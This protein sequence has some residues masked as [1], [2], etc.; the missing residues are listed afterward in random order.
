MTTSDQDDLCLA[1][2]HVFGDPGLLE[3]ALTHP[4]TENAANYER[5]EFLGDR[6]LG[7]VV[8]ELLFRAYPEEP[9][10][11]LAARLNS[12][13]SGG[14]LARMAAHINLDKHIKLGKGAAGPAITDNIL[15]NV[16]EAVIAALYLDGGLKPAADF[17]ERYWRDLVEDDAAKAKDAKTS[18][19]E[20]ALSRRVGLPL[21]QETGRIGPDHEP[22]F[23]I[24]V[25]VLGLGSASGTAGSKKAAERAAAAA[26]LDSV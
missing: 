2:G 7:F 4:S 16:C 19:Q 17:I 6:V 22:R 18:L 3:K 1:L 26:L 13:V 10:G 23:T 11:D 8:A 5:L 9:E 24:E 25:S 21:Y 15:A 14:T 12:L 20:L